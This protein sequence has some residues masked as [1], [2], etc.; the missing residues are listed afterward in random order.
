[1]LLIVA[2]RRR[3]R[4]AFV[5]KVLV[6]LE[7][8]STVDIHR[9]VAHVEEKVVR[10]DDV[11]YDRLEVHGVVLLIVGKFE[12]FGDVRRSFIRN[13]L[14][15]IHAYF[16]RSR[17]RFLRRS[18]VHLLWA[19][20]LVDSR[21]RR[22]LDA[23]VTFCGKQLRWFFN[24]PLARWIAKFLSIRQPVAVGVERAHRGP[25]HARLGEIHSERIELTPSR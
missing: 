21:S 18:A 7:C 25:R 20:R 15:R 22:I 4:R 9:S 14:L 12:E 13:F 11:V 1:M 16:E 23:R 19:H 2:R 17:F 24:S 10:G 6:H 8:L 3:R 5:G